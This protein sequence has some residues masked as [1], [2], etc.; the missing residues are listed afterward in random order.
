MCVVG[1]YRGDATLLDLRLGSRIRPLMINGKP[2]DEDWRTRDGARDEALPPVGAGDCP[3]AHWPTR[4]NDRHGSP[5]SA[6]DISPDGRRIV[7]G[8][9]NGVV[10]VWD[11]DTADLVREVTRDGHLV[12]AARFTPDGKHL[13]TVAQ[14]GGPYRAQWLGVDMW[15]LDTGELTQVLW[16]DETDPPFPLPC[17]EEVAALTRDGRYLATGHRS[18]TVTVHDLAAR[19][20]VGRLV[21]HGAITCLAFDGPRLLAGRANGDVTLTYVRTAAESSRG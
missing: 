2:C 15:S 12:R 3:R 7:T 10:R 20:R 1:T 6:L 8:T 17:D 16:P 5:V 11:A 21:L 19:E 9:L 18:G 13:I 14:L 4:I